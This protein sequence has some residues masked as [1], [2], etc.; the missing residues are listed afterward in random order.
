M[1]LVLF[2]LVGVLAGYGESSISV[3]IFGVTDSGQKEVAAGTGLAKLVNQSGGVPFD[4][5]PA[6]LWI[7][8][9]SDTER[10]R[11]IEV[12]LYEIV[13]NDLADVPLRE[14]QTIWAPQ[15]V[16]AHL[17]HEEILEFN[18]KL[19]FYVEHQA[20]A[21]SVKDPFA[22]QG[23]VP[24]HQATIEAKPFRL[25][26][27]HGEVES[28]GLGEAGAW[29]TGKIELDPVLLESL[30]QFRVAISGEEAGEY[31]EVGNARIAYQIKQEPDGIFDLKLYFKS[32]AE[33]G[34][35]EINTDV[36]L[37][38]SEWI[39]MGGLTRSESDGTKARYMMAVRIAPAVEV[40]AIP[41]ENLEMKITIDTERYPKPIIKVMRVAEL[42]EDFAKGGRRKV[43]TWQ[44][45]G[46]AERSGEVEIHLQEASVTLLPMTG[47]NGLRYIHVPFGEARVEATL[48]DGTKVLVE[49]YEAMAE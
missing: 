47:K 36:S 30:S 20:K 38:A 40:S 35:R 27:A 37:K 46:D 34:I 29:T 48:S 32:I 23:D 45:S 39:V 8:E 1:P 22:S 31:E 3:R 11:Q 44:T 41:F 10:R 42:Q 6:C 12:D 33:V 15:H 26:I 4:A 17:S 14:G 2:S 18:K 21:A 25:E 5:C 7:A 9:Q 49:Q 24:W 28:V 13:T 19:P 43:I 16:M